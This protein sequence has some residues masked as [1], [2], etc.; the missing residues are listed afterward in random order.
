MALALRRAALADRSSAIERTGWLVGGGYSL[1]D[2]SWAPTMATLERA[3]FPIG[4]F[5]QVRDWYDR[6]ARRPAW[7]RAMTQWLNPTAER[8]G[9][10]RMGGVT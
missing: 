1:A 9:E 3:S 8:M 2:I 4:A 6:I 7:Q 5:P 10:L